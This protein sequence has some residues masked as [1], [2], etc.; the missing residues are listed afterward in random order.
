MLSDTFQQGNA[1]LRSPRNGCS[2]IP[3]DKH[4]RILGESCA[5]WYANRSN[6]SNVAKTQ[7]DCLLLP[8]HFPLTSPPH[9]VPGLPLHLSSRPH[10]FVPPASYQ[11]PA[12]I[13]LRTSPS[14][15]PGLEQPN[16][17]VHH[18]TCQ[19]S[20]AGHPQHPSQIPCA[21]VGAIRQPHAD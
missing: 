3:E 1:A 15:P 12:P 6:P 4:Q 17:T 16:T 9:P 11:L 20:A 13:L 8:L 18:P 21:R 14:S 10:F 5:R 19:S 7:R 2:R